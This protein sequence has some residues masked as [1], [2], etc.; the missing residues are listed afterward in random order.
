MKTITKRFGLAVALL[1]AVGV[2]GRAEAAVITVDEFGNGVGTV[3]QGFLSNDPLPGGLNNVLTYNLPFAGLRGEVYLQ[4]QAAD[5]GLPSDT[6]RFDGN[7]HM[8][9]YSSNADGA[10]AMADVNSPTAVLTPNVLVFE[11][12]G[13]VTYTPT[14]SNP[15]FDASQPTYIFISDNETTPE[16]TSLTLAGLGAVCVIAYGKARRRRSQRKAS[17]EA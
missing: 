2:A 13:G 7:G 16:P 10:D 6:I 4:G 15:G 17:T 11:A 3:G 9:F 8:F 1:M 12:P 5:G 14:S